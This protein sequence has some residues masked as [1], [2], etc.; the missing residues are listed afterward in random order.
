MPKP[1]LA[2]LVVLVCITSASGPASSEA[3]GPRPELSGMPPRLGVSRLL[4]KVFLGMRSSLFLA[5]R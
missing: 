4:H 2:A 3:P 5:K 1:L